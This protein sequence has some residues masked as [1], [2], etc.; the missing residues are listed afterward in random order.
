MKLLE[1]SGGGTFL[2]PALG[3]QRQ[4]DLWVGG[5]PGLHCVFQYSQG[6]TEK[7]CLKKHQ[8]TQQVK[9]DS[10]S[11]WVA[12]YNMKDRGMKG[13]SGYQGL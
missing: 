4:A 3:K 12:E 7:P 6:S 13:T 8:P 9:L 5:Q 2:I 1:R 10:G 11:Q